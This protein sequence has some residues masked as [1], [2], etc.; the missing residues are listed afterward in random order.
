M[1]IKE[2]KLISKE[3]N[4][5]FPQLEC[6]A[7]YEFIYNEAF[8]YNY[9]DN[10]EFEYLFFGDILELQNSYVERCYVISYDGANNPIGIYLASSGGR[11]ENTIYFD[12]ILTYLLLSGSKSF[13]TVHNHPN[14]ILKKSLEDISIDNSLIELSNM[15]NIEYKEGLIITKDY[16]NILHQ[17]IY[18]FENNCFTNDESIFYEDLL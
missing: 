11:S 6:I 5:S 1:K 14:N 15:L 18:T 8:L 4:G 17:N 10:Y 7:E 13:I 3:S 16:M 12:N 2:Y 9:H